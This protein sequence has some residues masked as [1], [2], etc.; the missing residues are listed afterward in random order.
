[1][2]SKERVIRTLLR[3]IIELGFG[4]EGDRGDN[5]NES[6]SSSKLWSGL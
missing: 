5:G 1:M 6:S 3:V 2:T 4:F